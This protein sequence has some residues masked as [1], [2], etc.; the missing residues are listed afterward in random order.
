MSEALSTV[1]PSSRRIPL[2]VLDANELDTSMVE[3]AVAPGVT[4]TP[5]KDEGREKAHEAPVPLRDRLDVLEQLRFDRFTVIATACGAGGRIEEMYASA[6][7]HCA[8]HPVGESPSPVQ[9]FE[10][11]FMPRTAHP[12][13]FQMQSALLIELG[14]ML[15]ADTPEHLATLSSDERM[16]RQLVLRSLDTAEIDS[17]VTLPAIAYEMRSTLFDAL[18]T[19]FAGP[20]LGHRA[21]GCSPYTEDFE[22]YSVLRRE[23]EDVFD[24]ANQRFLRILHRPTIASE[25]PERLIPGERHLGVV[26]SRIFR[27]SEVH[28]VTA[29]DRVALRVTVGQGGGEGDAS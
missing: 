11:L 4:P 29:I 9:R 2:K 14:A 12:E 7:T 3:R 25:S 16:R 5:Q 18:A 23:L 1:S 21:V 6:Q 13:H 27:E 8:E 20:R 19:R 24:S 17:M 15:R 26:R 22:I 10:R 28:H